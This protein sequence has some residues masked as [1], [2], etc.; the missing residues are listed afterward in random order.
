[1]TFSQINEKIHSMPMTITMTRAIKP[2][3]V[4]KRIW[5]SK[6]LRFRLITETV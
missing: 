4:K 1:M 6:F 3:R 5:G 2:S